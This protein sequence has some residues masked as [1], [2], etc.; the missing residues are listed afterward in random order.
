MP[1][2]NNVTTMMK[3]QVLSYLFVIIA[4]VECI[5]VQINKDMY[6]NADCTPD[7]LLAPGIE[8]INICRPGVGGSI[9]AVLNGTTITLQTFNTLDCSST[10]QIM[11]VFEMGVC[12]PWTWYDPPV[13]FLHYIPYH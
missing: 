4:I 10:P 6:S 3:I 8:L 2:Q 11:G 9:L 5:P 13:Y 7:S 1:A 12:S